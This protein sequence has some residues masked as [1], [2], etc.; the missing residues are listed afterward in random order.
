PVG[1]GRAWR[2]LTGT[3]LGGYGSYAIGLTHP[4]EFASIGAVSGIMDI[5]LV[6]GLDQAA[7][8]GSPVGVQPPATTPT[9]A[10]PAPAGGTV[11]LSLLPSQAA[12][13]AVATYAF[14]DPDAD[15]AYYRGRMPV[16]LARNAHARAHGVQSVMI[17]GFSNDTIPRTAADVT[18]F[19]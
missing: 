14:G 7:T 18:S 2:A 6:H 17:R 5:L 4:D 9:F 19:P 16:D 12:D 13:F 8:D 11:P 3:S 1:R 15:G 10:V